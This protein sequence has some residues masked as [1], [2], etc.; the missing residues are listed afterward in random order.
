MTPQATTVGGQGVQLWPGRALSWAAG[1][2]LFV[3]DLHVDKPEALRRAFA[4]APLVA[5][6]ADLSRLSLLLR[7]TAASMLVILG[8]LYHAPGGAT[9][10][11][12]LAALRA[13]RDGHPDLRIT[14]VRG[15]HDARAGAPPEALGL[16]VVPEGT[17]LGPF[18][19][20]H[21]P[22]DDPRGYVLAGHRHPGVRLTGPGD[23][24]LRLPAFVLGPRR[25]V[26]PA[27]GALTGLDLRVAV[28][29]DRVFAVADEASV[30]AVV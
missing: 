9:S 7:T 1:A 23:D 3:A 2:T 6:H 28:R 30:V 26:L 5:L 13:W 29:G 8:D 24:R 14:L 4:P 19:L 22:A 11:A 17:P 10:P 20:R 27:Y 15:N 25:A 18:V 12:T 21:R 16:D